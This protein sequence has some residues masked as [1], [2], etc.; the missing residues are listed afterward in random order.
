MTC[1]K[2]WINENNNFEFVF[3]WGYLDNNHVQIFDT[4]GNLVWEIDFEKENP[5]L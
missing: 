2:V 4:A 3:W 5:T 1:Y